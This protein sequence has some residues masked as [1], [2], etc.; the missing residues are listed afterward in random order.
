VCC[1]GTSR[2]TVYVEK[3][4]SAEH[5]CCLLNVAPFAGATHSMKQAFAV[6][7]GLEYASML[8]SKDMMTESRTIGSH[9]SAT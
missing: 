5:H 1:A 3:E 6:A 8:A 2:A 9:R 7:Y 4:R